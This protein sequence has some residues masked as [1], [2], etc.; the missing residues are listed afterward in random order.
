MD[1]FTSAYTNIYAY[2]KK[3]WSSA[4]G[5]EKQ[6]E[7]AKIGSDLDAGSWSSGNGIEKEKIFFH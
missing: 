1:N 2:D 3:T 6:P 7:D 4:G 5:I